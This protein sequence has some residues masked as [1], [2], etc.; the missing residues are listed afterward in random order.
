VTNLTM[1]ESRRMFSCGMVQRRKY[2]I[3]CKMTLILKDAKTL[4]IG[5]PQ[6]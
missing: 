1:Q 5:N 3:T 2:L 6:P 4:L